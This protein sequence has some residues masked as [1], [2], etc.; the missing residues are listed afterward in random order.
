MLP[1]ASWKNRSDVPD[2]MCILFY[3]PVARK[4]AH[5]SHVKNSFGAPFGR[6]EEG[7]R[8]YFLRGKIRTEICQMKV[9]V[10]VV[11]KGSSDGNEDIGFTKR[12][13]IRTKAV[14]NALY[15]TVSVIPVPSIITT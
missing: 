6:I 14:Q 11:E 2:V 3:G 12:E 1:F 7:F 15:S 8:Y 5:P 9:M 4:L 13:G 10:T